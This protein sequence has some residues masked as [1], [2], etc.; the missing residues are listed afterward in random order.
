[1]Q[2]AEFKQTKSQTKA[3]VVRMKTTLREI[4][5]NKHFAELFDAN[6]YI[7]RLNKNPRQGVLGL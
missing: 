6:I 2:K 4:L 3:N 7:S 5:Y 1:L